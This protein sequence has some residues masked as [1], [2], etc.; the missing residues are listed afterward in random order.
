MREELRGSAAGK[1][2]APNR[3][4]YREITSWPTEIPV[5]AGILRYLRDPDTGPGLGCLLASNPVEGLRLISLCPKEL[6]A[7]IS[8]T[9]VR[10]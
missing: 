10:N 7:A 1:F 6:A 8:P 9:L 3:P 2:A 4:N 5:N